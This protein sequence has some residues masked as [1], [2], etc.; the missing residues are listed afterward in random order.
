MNGTMWMVSGNMCFVWTL[1]I[2]YRPPQYPTTMDQ[3]SKQQ[4]MAHYDDSEGCI[5]EAPICRAEIS[6]TRV[7]VSTYI[8]IIIEAGGGHGLLNFSTYNI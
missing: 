8:G 1:N 2:G 4:H 6:L 5:K 7:I 3:C